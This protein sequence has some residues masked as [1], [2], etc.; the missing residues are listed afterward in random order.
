LEERIYFT[1]AAYNAGHGH[2]HDARRLARQLGKDPNR[3]FGNVEQA[4]LLLSQPQYSRK[5]QFGYVRG[6]EP[7]AYVRDIR[8]RY[9]G[10]LDANAGSED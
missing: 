3:W 5:A 1:L 6:T 8:D 2:V 9:V 4:M 7:V 10:Y